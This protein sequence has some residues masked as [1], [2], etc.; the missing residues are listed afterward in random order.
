MPEGQ[1][2]AGADDR[3]QPDGQGGLDWQVRRLESEALA[4]ADEHGRLGNKFGTAL[5]SAIPHMFV[6]VRRSCMGPTNMA[7]RMIRPVAVARAA[8]GKMV[9]TGGMGMLGT[10]MTCLLAWGRRGIDVTS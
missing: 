5:R 6:F 4:I 2:S 9:T 1:G 3:G 10:L 7:E 8:R